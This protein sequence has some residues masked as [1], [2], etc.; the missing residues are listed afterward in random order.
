MAANDQGWED[1]SKF[2][3]IRTLL[4]HLKLSNVGQFLS[5]YDQEYKRIEQVISAYPKESA[6]SLIVH[7]LLEDLKRD[8]QFFQTF[9]K[10]PNELLIDLVTRV[11]KESQ[12]SELQAFGDI[13][14]RI[15]DPNLIIT[16]DKALQEH[17]FVIVIVGQFH[18]DIIVE[19]LTLRGGIQLQLLGSSV[20]GKCSPISAQELLPIFQTLTALKS[21]APCSVCH[22]FG[23][24]LQCSRCKAVNYCS[25]QCQKNDWPKHK[26]NCSH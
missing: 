4:F 1:L 24:K 25:A 13:G 2:K 7:K 19:Y 23:P 6:A 3:Q 11:W 9:V 18:V 20:R 8:R 10:N 22:T 26:N 17:D 5:D 16:L 14:F 12:P 21:L 15:A